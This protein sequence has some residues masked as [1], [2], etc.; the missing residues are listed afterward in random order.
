M[1]RAR[2]QGLRGG[3]RVECAV[4]CDGVDSGAWVVCI[5]KCDVNCRCSVPCKLLLAPKQLAL[6]LATAL[7][8]LVARPCIEIVVRNLSLCNCGVLQ[9]YWLLGGMMCYKHCRLGG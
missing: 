5:Q 2:Y 9:R 1:V 8:E 6:S 7:G 4:R 3:E